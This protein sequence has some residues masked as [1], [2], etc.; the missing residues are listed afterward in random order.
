MEMVRWLALVLTAATAL[1]SCKAKAGDMPSAREGDAGDAH[2]AGEASASTPPKADDRFGEAGGACA[3]PD[4]IAC[5]TDLAAQLR[6]I[7]GK[8]LRVR[9]CRRPPCTVTGDD[10]RC[11]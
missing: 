7:D 5:S 8:W 10:L 9:V 11:D 4:Q 1:S 3:T 6:C 2:V